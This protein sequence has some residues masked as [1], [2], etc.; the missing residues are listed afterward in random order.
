MQIRRVFLI[1][2]LLTVC[3]LSAGAAWRF[4][5]GPGDEAL[6]YT[7]VTSATAYS[8]GVGYGFTIESG[9]GTR[10]R[11]SDSSCPSQ[12]QL[13]TDL[14]Y[15]V[16]PYEFK[17]DVPNGDYR[18]R[19]LTGEPISTQVAYDLIVEGKTNPVPA[20]AKYDVLWLETDATITDGQLNLY[21]DSPPGTSRVNFNALTV[22]PLAEAGDLS[23]ETLPN[24]D[25]LIHV[26]PDLVVLFNGADKGGN[27]YLG[28]PA[29]M[30]FNGTRLLHTE[31]VK[32]PFYVTFNDT[33]FPASM[34]IKRNGDDLIEI[35]S[36]FPVTYS[37]YVMQTHYI[38]RRGVPGMYTHHVVSNA[39][40][41]ANI[42]FIGN[43]RPVVRPNGG[44]FHTS[45]SGDKWLMH[46]YSETNFVE[47][48]ADAT[49]RLDASITN[50]AFYSKYEQATYAKNDDVHGFLNDNLGLWVVNPSK[51]AIT[52]GPMK[53]YNCVHQTIEYPVLLAY[54]HGSHFITAPEDTPIPAGGSKTFGPWLL[55]I[56][57]GS[58]ITGMVADAEAR[59][60]AEQAAW[61]YT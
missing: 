27:Q 56:N 14:I 61:P 4:D 40:P 18:V 42:P 8:A 9:Y 30:E 52:G 16:N 38:F 37:N 47:E 49:Y 23:L 53:Q 1:Y 48:V 60:A 10:D 5:F 58:S 32:I 33:V 25:L 22:E 24:N 21:F 19:V 54:Y 51:E 11:M 55:Y 29:Q 43:F 50:D 45:Y 26:P 2:T 28:Y 15:N 17:L 35:V 39:L 20:R 3:C 36:D 57:E 44:L 13:V 7:K 6:G 41:T 34:A 59:A 12:S 46:M 31:G